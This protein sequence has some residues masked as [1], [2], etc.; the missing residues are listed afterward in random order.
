MEEDRSIDES[1]FSLEKKKKK[2]NVEQKKKNF[3]GRT[4]TR[5]V[6]KRSYVRFPAHSVVAVGRRCWSNRAR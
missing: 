5:Y 6:H 2:E 4:L 3:N 1:F